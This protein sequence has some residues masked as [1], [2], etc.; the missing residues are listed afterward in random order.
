[1]AALVRDAAP[2][3]QILQVKLALGDVDERAVKL[4]AYVGASSASRALGWPKGKRDAGRVKRAVSDWF[5]E[6]LEVTRPRSS[7]LRIALAELSTPELE[8]F[9]L[10]FK[11]AQEAITDYW[12]GPVVP[13][14]GG[15]L[16]E[17]STEDFCAWIVGEGRGVWNRSLENGVDLVALAQEMFR[18]KSRPDPARPQWDTPVESVCWRVYENRSDR[19]RETIF[20]RV[21]ELRFAGGAQLLAFPGR[22]A[23]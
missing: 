1:M 14:A 20:E 10:S 12:N 4:A 13:E 6:L 7:E 18:L 5:W 3:W 9:Q 23:T 17:V 8:L 19:R 11:V 22:G 16:S 21:D 2:E 15:A